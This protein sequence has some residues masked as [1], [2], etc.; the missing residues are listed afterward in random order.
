[1][2]AIQRYDEAY[3]EEDCA[4]ERTTKRL[5]EVIKFRSSSFASERRAAFYGT[6]S[7]CRTGGTTGTIS[8]S[9]PK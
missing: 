4:K 5:S 7:C 9:I 3:L 2:D 1:M 8:D 6:G